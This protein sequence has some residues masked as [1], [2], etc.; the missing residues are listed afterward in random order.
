MDIHSMTWYIENGHIYG[1]IYYTSRNGRR[2][3]EKTD[4]TG[5]TVNQMRDYL[6][7]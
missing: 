1:L 5:Y 6:N 4:L 7:Y 3:E 2:G